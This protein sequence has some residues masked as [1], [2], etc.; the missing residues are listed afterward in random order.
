MKKIL[1]TLLTIGAVSTSF[2]DD[3]YKSFFDDAKLENQQPLQF[4]AKL[5]LRDLN[6]NQLSQTTIASGIIYSLLTNTQYKYASSKQD[7]IIFY[8]GMS[9]KY[10][11]QKNSI[12]VNYR[13]ENDTLNS[14]LNNSTIYNVKDII[15]TVPLNYQVES[16]T[17]AVTESVGDTYTIHRS[18]I[19]N[20][21][22][23]DPLDAP[24]KLYLDLTANLNP[25]KII[26]P[27][28]YILS[29]EIDNKY[30]ADSVYG[31][32]DRLM[33][34]YDWSINPTCT[35]IDR[36]NQRVTSGDQIMPSAYA[37]C[38]P[39][40]DKQPK[41]EFSQD[42]YGGNP[43]ITK[44][45][46]MAK[47]KGKIGAQQSERLAPAPTPTEYAAKFGVTPQ[48]MANTYSY[49][50]GDLTIPVVINVFP[51]HNQSKVSYKAII[52]Y[53]IS[54]DGTISITPAQIQQIKQDIEKVV[55]S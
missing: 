47:A 23:Q 4:T 51:Y 31:N 33:G 30:S 34:K 29:N 54:G 28:Q 19:W 21:G 13:N 53:T 14:V 3:G 46:E 10:D 43:L 6:G 38:T 24:I 25:Q 45:M 9:V 15:F 50:F 5:P 1:L 49:K 26:I 20:W 44:M 7:K 48:Q 8:K 40:A 35:P 27:Q 41:A 37:M 32:F 12:I 42:N 11:N 22:T 36:I 39:G 17:I 18:S 55:N 52:P 2:A 16:K